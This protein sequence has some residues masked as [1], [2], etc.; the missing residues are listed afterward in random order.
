MSFKRAVIIGA[1]GQDGYYL[2]KFLNSKQYQVFGI[3]KEMHIKKKA[4]FEKY[5]IYRQIALIDICNYEK[6]KSFLLQIKPDEIY[7]LAT[8]HESKLEF[9]NYND[10]FDTNVKSLAIILDIVTKHLKRK[11]RTFFASSSNIYMG[12][13]DWPQNEA[14]K[15]E[16]LT[17]YGIA[18]NCSMDLIRSYRQRYNLFSCSGILYNHESIRRSPMYLPRKVSKAVA[19][20][21]LNLN[22]ELELNNLNSIADWGHSKDYVRAMWMMLQNKDPQDFIISTGKA[23]SVEELVQIAFGTLSLDYKN[24]VVNL[25]KKKFFHT[26]L[27]GDNNKI[28]TELGW[29]PKISFKKLISELVINDFNELKNSNWK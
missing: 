10:T 6:M 19:E 11:P 26:P 15:P 18:K 14:L 21:A 24:Y 20:I 3:S 7:H 13:S 28:K 4:L 29:S 12:C 9:N 8:T 23:Y 5:C 16:P 22:E 25:N 2:S 1:F 17:Y 27:I